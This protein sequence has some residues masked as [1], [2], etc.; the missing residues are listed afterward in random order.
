MQ[1]DSHNEVV[2]PHH[3]YAYYRH[4]CRKDKE[5]YNYES[6]YRTKVDPMLATSLLHRSRLFSVP[7][8]AARYYQ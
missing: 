6:L 5:P 3:Y 4:T 1:T 8:M 2:S 7:L